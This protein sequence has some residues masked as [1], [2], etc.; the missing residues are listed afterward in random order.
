MHSQKKI[1]IYMSLLAWIVVMVV[2]TYFFS[3]YLEAQNNPNT[4]P[5]NQV[6]SGGVRQVK[7]YA[8]RANHYVLN[9]TINN[10]EVTMLL[11]TGASYV[12]VPASLAKK[13][14][15][16]KGA[17]TKVSTANGVVTAYMTQLDQVVIGNMVFNDI[18]AM[19][20]P[21][22]ADNQVLLGMSLLKHVDMLYNYGTLI[23][24]QS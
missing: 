3:K 7:L 8:N 23:M 18:T 4:K 9:A 12:T 22:A 10:V 14:G 20:N 17:P 6:G 13:M 19:I 1:G 5:E 11:D 21:H 16:R 2:L 24:Q 15:L